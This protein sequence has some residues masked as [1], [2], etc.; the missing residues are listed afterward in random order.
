MLLIDACYAMTAMMLI[1]FS[2]LCR[3]HAPYAAML[4]L[5]IARYG[6][7]SYAADVISLRQ[8]RRCYF[9]DAFTPRRRHVA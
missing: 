3:R 6:A 9:S 2:P 8:L 5:L 1:D 7:I 4:P